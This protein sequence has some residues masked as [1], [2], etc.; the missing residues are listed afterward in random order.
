MAPR[1]TK[2]AKVTKYNNQSQR[3]WSTNVNMH[4]EDESF[5]SKNI[6]YEKGIFQG[7]YLFYF[8]R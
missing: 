3:N 1:S 2:T 8:I 7:V 4:S 5:Q 6:K